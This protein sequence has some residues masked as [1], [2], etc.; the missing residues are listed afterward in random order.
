[1]R[2]ATRSTRDRLG[3][4]Y[5]PL[6]S[7]RKL[8]E[9]MNGVHASTLHT[10]WSGG[11]CSFDLENE[12]REQIELPPLKRRRRIRPTA[13]KQQDKERR[14]LGLT[15]PQVIEDG[16]M[17]NRL[18]KDLRLTMGETYRAILYYAEDVYGR[19]LPEKEVQD[20]R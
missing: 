6:R 14:D 12:I 8:S 19:Q 11:S 18:A 17:T 15:W 9:T 3:A 1:M 7:W 10:V 20:S 13:T 16:L 5:E 2:K 4:L